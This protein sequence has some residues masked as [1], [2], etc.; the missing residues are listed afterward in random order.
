MSEFPVLYTSVR[1]REVH[2][3]SA[4]AGRPGPRRGSSGRRGGG[5]RRGNRRPRV[6]L[7]DRPHGPHGARRDPG[8]AR[9][10]GPYGQLSPRGGHAL[11][12][13]GA[14]RDVRGRACGRARGRGWCSARATCVSA[15]CAASSG[16]RIRTSSTTRWRSSKASWRWS[17]WSCC[18]SSLP[19]GAEKHGAKPGQSANSKSGN[20]AQSQDRQPIPKAGIGVSPCF[21][22]IGVS[23]CFAGPPC[24]R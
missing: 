18:A 6:E 23:P 24:G 4:A 12:H 11:L 1:G 15:A 10:R 17:A 16:W 22:G 19:R 9:S 3:R 14:V 7:A 21:A 5:Y 20:C 2:A 13:A 8:V